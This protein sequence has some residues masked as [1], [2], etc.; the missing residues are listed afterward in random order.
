M[1]P[2]D[3]TAYVPANELDR[4]IRLKEVE[5]RS[6]LEITQAINTNPSERDLYKIFSFTLRANLS[7][8]RLSLFVREGEQWVCR[9][10][11][12]TD[13]AITDELI[14]VHVPPI[15]NIY[16][17]DADAP[18]VFQTFEYIIPVVQDGVM[19]AYVFLGQGQH[20][21]WEIEESL[22]FIRTLSNILLV[23][24]ENK[25]LIRS[26]IEQESLRR[27]VQ[28][29]RHVQS[30]LFP[31]A[32]PSTSEREVYASYQPHKVVGGDYYDY[33]PLPNDCFLLCIA[34]VSGKGIPAALLMSNFQASLH[35][36]VR[37]TQRLPDIVS[38]LNY[39][40]RQNAGGEHFITFFVAIFDPQRGEL[41]YINAG[42]NPPL[43]FEPDGTLH[44]LDQG[45]TI[46]GIFDPLPFLRMGS[47][48][49]TEFLL[50]AYTDGLTE[51]KNEREEEYSDDRMCACV[52]RHRHLPLPKLH[53]Q[54]LHDL[55]IFKDTM[56]YADDI[57][58]L[59]AR[60]SASRE[61]A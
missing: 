25:K 29:A 6:L 61:D 23:A 36:L 31:K 58:L 40:I 28:I 33:I 13:T 45:T 21:G 52:R 41:T 5:V 42:H 55:E 19:K 44:L 4:R 1:A 8:Q 34:D 57:T 60:L 37:Q 43:L 18:A 14:R 47:L 11:F 7:T 17:I 2:R 39:H 59:S 24:I 50:F 35:T 56:D 49:L 26:Q 54:I 38:E 15:S 12:G 27:E 20:S 10:N 32:L 46:L 30:L 53:Q 16:Q 48:R 3:K 9:V 22:S 51:V